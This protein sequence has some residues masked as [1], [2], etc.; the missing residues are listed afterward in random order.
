MANALLKG[1]IA[2]LRVPRYPGQGVAARVRLS[3]VAEAQGTRRGAT[4]V[5]RYAENVRGEVTTWNCDG[6]RHCGYGVQAE[7][8]DYLLVVTVFW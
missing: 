2:R 8:E 6:V 5:E 1:H 3:E 7:L 4:L